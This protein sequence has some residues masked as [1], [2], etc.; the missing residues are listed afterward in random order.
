ME[1]FKVDCL[2][3]G[4]GVSGLAIANIL[5]KN[6]SEVFLIEK[7]KS[8]GLEASGR[9]SEVI[10]A[11]IYYEKD[12]LKSKFCLRG[13][14][15]LY[16]YLKK[17]NIEYN[18]CGKYILATNHQEVEELESLKKNAINCGLKD[19]EYKRSLENI[20]PFLKSELSLFS[21]SSGIFD[22]YS[23]FNSLEKEFV[24]NNGK[25]LFGNESK[26]YEVD[27]K[28]FKI[29]VSDVL[30]NEEYILETKLLINCAGLNSIKIANCF[31]EKESYQRK[32]IKGEYYSYSGKEKLN[33]LI[34][35]MPNK[36]SLGLHA[37]ID[38]GKGIRFGP[39]AYETE[40]EDY[41]IDENEKEKFYKSIL[42]YWP[43]IEKENLQPNYSGIR[44]T[45][46]GEKDFLIDQKEFNENILVNVL[47]YVSP[48][49]T[50]SLALAEYILESISY[51]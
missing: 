39:S 51:K 43:G 19:L 20:Y 47:G 42:K 45:I 3:I 29:N 32:L 44:A 35:P 27:D 38:L 48:G 8:L 4:G 7:N 1:V 28:S 17:N 9:N 34:Y 16:E 36:N 49:L 40:K 33:H 30:N 12:S 2:V 10:H 5:S 14:Y 11:G 18:N 22:S 26:N 50:S 23:F 31:S 6:I 37:T 21:P 13:K 46:N 41:F 25:V 24:E 15:L